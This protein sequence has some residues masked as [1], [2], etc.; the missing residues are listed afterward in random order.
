MSDLSPTANPDM[1]VTKKAT[2]GYAMY[3]FWVMFSISFLNYL[4]RNVLSGA[5]NVVARLATIDHPPMADDFV[6]A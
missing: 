5:A 6:A 1:G 4:D 3:V 2:R